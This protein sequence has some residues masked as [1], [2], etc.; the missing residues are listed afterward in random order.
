MTQ[1]KAR[2]CETDKASSHK[3]EKDKIKK[4]KTPG[5]QDAHG[6]DST[7]EFLKAKTKTVR[8]NLVQHVFCPPLLPFPFPPFPF[9]V[10]TRPSR[11][12]RASAVCR[13]PAPS[14]PNR[15][16]RLACGVC[17]R[18]RGGG[19]GW[20]EGLRPAPRGARR[21]CPSAQAP[22]EST[23]KQ[24]DRG[25]GGQQRR[26]PDH[27]GRNE[28]AT[29]TAK[30][31]RTPPIEKGKKNKKKHTTK[32][33]PHFTYPMV[34]PNSKTVTTKRAANLKRSRQLN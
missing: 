18:R 7:H 33:G 8:P 26:S 6:H 10:N 14:G 17:R 34:D 20:G 30:G 27:V 4:E 2:V 16:P 13:G 29:A 9:L 21:T 22:Q 12:D 19:R 3:K 31:K 24:R 5:Y 11:C 28:H 25:S 1:T 15:T 23:H 32:R